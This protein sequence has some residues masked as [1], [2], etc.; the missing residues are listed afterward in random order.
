MRAK[1]DANVSN[2]ANLTSLSHFKI[3]NAEIK[4]HRIRST[5]LTGGYLEVTYEYNNM[6]TKRNKYAKTAARE[7]RAR[8]ARDKKR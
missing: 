6:R 7:A 1:L 2:F 3:Y 8:Y 4:I 5:I